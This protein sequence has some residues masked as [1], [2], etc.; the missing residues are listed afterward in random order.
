[1]PKL[2]KVD[3]IGGLMLLSLIGLIFFIV[4]TR[5]FQ[6]LQS[7]CPSSILRDGWSLIQAL[8]A[9]LFALGI[10]YFLC[11]INGS[12]YEGGDNNSDSNT[13]EVYMAFFSILFLVILIM[14]IAMLVQYSKLTDQE[15]SNCDSSNTTKNMTIMVTVMSGFGLLASSGLLIHLNSSEMKKYLGGS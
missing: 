7:S 10:S 8:G 13:A 4:S 5:V 11:A 6:N 3:S 14:C 1:M 9:G 2:P 15:K 12:C